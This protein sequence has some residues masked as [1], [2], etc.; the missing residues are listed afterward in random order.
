MLEDSPNSTLS[1]SPPEAFP[2]PERTDVQEPSEDSLGSDQ[3]DD[4]CGRVD[5]A[6][7]EALLGEHSD[8]MMRYAIKASESADPQDRK[9]AAVI[10]SYMMTPEAIADL[11]HLSA[12]AD[13]AVAKVAKERMSTQTEPNDYY[14]IGEI[15]TFLQTFKAA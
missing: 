7:A 15:D 1:E 13:S 2:A 5:A 8:T 9:L 11:R 4:L 14:D 12:D 10:F 6:K 3:E